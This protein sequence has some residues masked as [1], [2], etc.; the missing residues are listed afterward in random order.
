MLLLLYTISSA[1]FPPANADD[2]SPDD[3]AAC[4][5]Y[6]TLYSVISSCILTLFACTWTSIHPNIPSPHETMFRVARRRAGIML[7][8]LVAPELVILWAMRQFLHAGNVAKKFNN[9]VFKGQSFK[10]S[11]THGFFAMMGGFMLY[12]NHKPHHTLAPDELLE[13]VLSESV[14]QHQAV[15]ITEDEVEDRSKGD[16]I[17]KTVLILQ[18]TWFVTQYITR[19]IEHLAITQL[20]VGTLAFAVLNLVTYCF[21]WKKPLNVQRPHRVYLKDEACKLQEP[22]NT[23]EQGQ[24]WDTPI[25]RFFGPFFGMMGGLVDHQDDLKLYYEPLRVPTFLP[26]TISFN[27]KRDA[28]IISLVGLVVM[29]IFGGLHCF[30]WFSQFPTP[31]EQVSWRV[32]SLI[33]TGLPL[34]VVPCMLLVSTNFGETAIG[35]F[36]FFILPVT[37]FIARILLLTLM[38]TGLRSLPSDAYKAVSWI[39]LIPHL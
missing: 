20:E 29:V 7:A 38:V 26:I 27:R 33:I 12:H 4:N 32:S 34:F 15:E 31:L 10:W 19:Y 22:C 25:Y 30:A 3:I 8:A 28:K 39:Y 9:E 18:I 13:L 37:Y 5:G 17:S 35:F 11:R 21:W 24:E 36:L 2:L 16:M 1:S 6:R 14:D 23:K